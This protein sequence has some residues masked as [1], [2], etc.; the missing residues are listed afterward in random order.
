MKNSAWIG[1]LALGGSLLFATGFASE[2]DRAREL[3]GSGA[4]VPLEDIL[5]HTRERYPTARIL[6]V[7]LESKRGTY[8][9]EIELLDAAGVV[10]EL[11]YDAVTGELLE[12]DVDD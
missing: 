12:E 5:V 7:E 6:E 2:Q 11:K 10:Y 1:L 8:Y 4:I 9:Y 3:A